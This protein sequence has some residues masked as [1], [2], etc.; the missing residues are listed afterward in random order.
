L[1]TTRLVLERVPNTLLLSGAALGLAVIA[2]LPLGIASA[3]R[4]YS[5]VDYAATVTAFLGVSIPVFW[6]GIMFIIIFSVHLRWLPSAGMVT[7]GEPFR[8][9]DLLRHLI[10]PAAVLSTFPTAQL[11][12]YTR[13]SMVEV[14]AQD[15]IRTARAKGLAEIAVL[16]RHAFRNA[17]IPVVTVLGVIVPRLLGGTVITESIFAWPGLGRL[18]VDSAI[19]RDYPVIMGIT[20]FVAV[21]V[22]LGNL[23]ADLAYVALDP[24]IKLE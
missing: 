23:A 7:A 3:V 11:A 8:Y 16:G 19:T 5:V 20:M 14:V 22:I 15:Y 6:L 12:R 17:L 24:R 18:A 21:L 9:S 4:R 1:P 2:A 10:M 13:S